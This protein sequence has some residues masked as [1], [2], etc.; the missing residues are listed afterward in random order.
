[1]SEGADDLATALK[2]ALK[3]WRRY[4]LGDVLEF[5]EVDR[6]RLMRWLNAGIITTA[7]GGSQGVR[8]EFSFR[9]LIEVAV[10]DELRGLGVN[11]DGLRRTVQDLQT[12]WNQPDDPTSGGPDAPTVRD[13]IVLWIAFQ[14]HSHP[15]SG[16]PI[17]GIHLYPITAA[18]LLSRVTDGLADGSGIAETGIAVPIARIVANLERQTGDT[19]RWGP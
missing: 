17:E 15:V 7:G 2:A 8:R 14:R 1:M 18:Q 6:N 4:S 16:E 10:C 3:Q 19:L 13:A 12:I 9:N 11:E 5:T